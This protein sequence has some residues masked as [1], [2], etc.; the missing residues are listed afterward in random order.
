MSSFSFFLVFS[1]FF[2]Q[3]ILTFILIKLAYFSIA[4]YVAKQ[5]SDCMYNYYLVQ[6]IQRKQLLLEAG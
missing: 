1:F 6:F 3:H 4:F 2:A 5:K